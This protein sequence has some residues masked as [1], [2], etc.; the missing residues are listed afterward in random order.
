MHMY[1]DWIQSKGTTELLTLRVCEG[2]PWRCELL[3]FNSFVGCISPGS[4]GLLII[5]SWYK[6]SFSFFFFFPQKTDEE[7]GG[8]RL[9]GM[10]NILFIFFRF[11]RD[12]IVW[13]LWSFA[14]LQSVPYWHSYRGYQRKKSCC[15][16]HQM[17][18]VGEAGLLSLMDYL[19]W[20]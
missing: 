14:R 19:R 11:N 20:M 8:T 10:F 17:K 1:E 5:A 2:G 12:L 16:K 13:F 15:I 6:S 7:N 18:I 3:V 9:R 4:Y